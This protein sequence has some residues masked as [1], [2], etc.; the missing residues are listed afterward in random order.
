MIRYKIT[1]T[2][3]S[4]FLIGGHQ[5]L[6]NHYETLDYIPA[7]NLQAAIA[8]RILES[9]GG[10]DVQQQARDGQKRYFIDPDLIGVEGCEEKWIPWFQHF[11]QLRFTDATPF[12]AEHFTA[13]TF[14][15][16]LDREHEETDF[17]VA[18]YVTRHHRKG[19]LNMACSC[20]E[21]L[22][23]RSGWKWPQG[24]RM[25]KRTVTRVALDDRRHVSADGQL[26][27][28]Q[29]GEPYADAERTPLLFVGYLLVPESVEKE[30]NFSIHDEV[31]RIGKHITVG[32][33][34]MNLEVER[35]ETDA[36]P[37]ARIAR[38]QT[39]SGDTS[40]PLLINGTLPLAVAPIEGRNMTISTRTARHTQSG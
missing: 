22:E 31:V 19:R 24:T 29:I 10:Y 32:L 33:G 1:L 4:P 28:L 12:G 18:F 25:F 21:R 17:L 34:K 39:L 7:P 5:V 11:S 14:G 6:D 37:E 8:R 40:V 20:G 27:S 26:F 9:H 16:K 35:V 23:R 38:W 15:C 36:F 13:S 3:L 30:M 2:P